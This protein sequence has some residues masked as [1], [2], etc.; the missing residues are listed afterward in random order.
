[1][2][3]E[4]NADNYS[5]SGSRTM[6]CATCKAYSAYDPTSGICSKFKFVA[7]PDF[8][9]DAWVGS[10][11]VKKA[12]DLSKL[13]RMVQEAVGDEEKGTNDYDAMADEAARVHAE[14]VAALAESHATDERRHHRVDREMLELVHAQES[15]KTP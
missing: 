10:G 7:D 8:V 14:E 6:R 9:C 13:K 3:S 11:L 12:E 15:K 2:G 4:L 5:F 1:M